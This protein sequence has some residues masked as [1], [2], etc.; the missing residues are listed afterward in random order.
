MPHYNSLPT[1]HHRNQQAAEDLAERIRT[2]PG[3]ANRRALVN[4]VKGK[5]LLDWEAA[6]R[7]TIECW[8]TRSSEKPFSVDAIDPNKNLACAEATSL[9][10]IRHLLTRPHLGIGCDRILKVE[11]EAVGGQRPGLFEGTGIGPR[12]V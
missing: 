12:H 1:V 8:L 3:V 7:E 2:A 11:N 4:L 9:D 5:L 10:R 6:D